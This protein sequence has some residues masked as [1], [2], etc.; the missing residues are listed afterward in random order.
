MRK[1]IASEVVLEAARNSQTASRVEKAR[2][3][4]AVN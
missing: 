2:G 4:T 1:K 3:R